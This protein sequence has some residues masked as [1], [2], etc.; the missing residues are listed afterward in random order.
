MKIG[1]LALQGDVEEHANAFKE[2]GR[3]VGVDVDVVEVKKPGDL[4]DI[5]A[6]A[7]PGGESTTIGRLA[8]RTGLLDAVK[9][10]IEGGVPALGTCAGAIFMAKEVK[11]AVVG[12]TGQPVLGVMDIAVVRNAFGRQRE[13][14]EAEVVLENL[15]KLKAVFIRAPAFVRAWGSAKLLAPLRHNQLG[16]VYAAAVQNN[17]VATAFHPELTTTAVH[18]WVINMALG[19]F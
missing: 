5:K 4:K 10:A 16:L 11:D 13:S 3:E 2:A 7:I 17:M 15:G 14:F 12:A 18:K 6:L 9:K 19:R 1:V 8:K